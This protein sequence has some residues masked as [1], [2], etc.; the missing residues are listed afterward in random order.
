MLKAEIW[1][2]SVF[3]SSNIFATQTN[4]IQLDGWK[5]LNRNLKDAVRDQ[6]LRLWSNHVE[7]NQYEHAPPAN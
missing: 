4:P 3:D 6:A 5:S 1:S 2:G 7:V